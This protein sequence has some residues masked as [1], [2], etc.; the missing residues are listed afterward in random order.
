MWNSIPVGFGW[1]TRINPYQQNRELR[2][3]P[4]AL[5]SCQSRVDM[6]V[7][8]P[9]KYFQNEIALFRLRSLNVKK[10]E[11]NPACGSLFLRFNLLEINDFAYSNVLHLPVR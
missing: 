2:D 1:C 5:Y 4:S 6:V 3:F 11:W 10:P 9:D 8:V 7:F